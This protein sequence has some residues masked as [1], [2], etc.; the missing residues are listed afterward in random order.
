VPNLWQAPLRRLYSWLLAPV[1]QAGLLRG[2]RSLIVVPHAEL[3]YLPFGALQAERDG[4]FVTLR[5]AVSY[6]PSATAWLS[7]AERARARDN[8]QVLALAPQPRALPAT[9]GEVEG[10]QEVFGRRASVIVGDA[11]TETSFR[12]AAAGKS[13]LHLA[14]FGVLNKHNP[15]FSFVALAPSGEDDGRL[16]VHEVFGLMLQAR[17]VVLSACQTG[18]GSGALADVPAGDD[19]VGLVHAFLAAGA[20]EVLASLWPVED[21]ATARLMSTFYRA[22]A[23]GSSAADALSAAQ[24]AALSDAA[25]ADPFY[26]AGFTLAGQE[27]RRTP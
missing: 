18:V 22:I 2:T 16:E 4:G 26:W 25:T 7:L 21:R 5:Y 17:L 3:H 23:R 27:S 6:A 10:I 15:L 8:G 11:A 9:R 24:R 13:I 12:A 14:T 19:W 1:E 20:G